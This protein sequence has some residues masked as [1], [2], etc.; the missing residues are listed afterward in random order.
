[1][2]STTVVTMYFNI[3]NFKDATEAV[4]PRS[5]YMDK[6]RVT[7]K[8]LAPMI[9]YCDES[10]LEDIKAIRGNLPTEYVVKEITDYEFFKDNY[11]IITK[12]RE[13]N[14]MYVNSRNTASYCLL[15]M[16]KIYAMYL[17]SQANPFQTT[18]FAWIDF[19][20]S[21]ILRDL[22]VYGPLMLAAPRPKIALCYI[23]YRSS[24][25]LAPPSAFYRGGLCGI[26]ATAFTVEESYAS[27]FYNGCMS[28]FH[29]MLLNKTCHA[30]EHV[31]T[32]FYDK[33]PALCDIYYGDYYSVV[34]NYHHVRQ[35]F[36]SIWHHFI[37]E[38]SRKNRG[39]LAKSCA[40][41]VL[42]SVEKGVL[43]LSPQDIEHLNGINP[44]L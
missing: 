40:K 18:H 11:P 10:C 12:N 25:E 19:G 26:A 29:D 13:G 22:Q 36:P 6:G 9:V 38:A 4:R 5:F 3:K 43:V 44:S 41:A 23:H 39:D 21:H 15:T 16:F 33:Y 31:M 2:T 35:D 24:S 20:G 30:E 17:S 34:S 7:L 27:N 32:Y 37:L 14:G 28:I 8:L 42:D 1:M